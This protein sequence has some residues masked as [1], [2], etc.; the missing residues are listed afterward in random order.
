[1]PFHV[2]AQIPEKWPIF[3]RMDNNPKP[4]IT[5][6]FRLFMSTFFIIGAIGIALG[7]V[8]N[9]YITPDNRWLIAMPFLFYGLFRLYMA[10]RMMRGKNDTFN[11]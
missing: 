5:A 1:M 7:L 9:D 3:A 10:I 6:W 8:D 11:S 2:P 4:G